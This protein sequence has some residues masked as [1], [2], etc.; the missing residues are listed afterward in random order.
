MPRTSHARLSP[1]ST[2]TLSV[3]ALLLTAGCV[4]RSTPTLS[5]SS[6]GAA[7]AQPSAETSPTTGGALWRAWDGNRLGLV[8]FAASVDGELFLRGGTGTGEDYVLEECAIDLETGEIRPLERLFSDESWWQL[9]FAYVATA[10]PPTLLRLRVDRNPLFQAAVDNDSQAPPVAAWASTAAVGRSLDAPLDFPSPVNADLGEA[11]LG[12][13]QP[14]AKPEQW[15]HA[16]EASDHDAVEDTRFTAPVSQVLCL[17]ERQQAVRVDLPQTTR[18]PLDLMPCRVQ[19]DQAH[20]ITEAYTPVPEELDWFGRY[21]GLSLVELGIELVDGRAAATTIF[22]PTVGPGD[23]AIMTSHTYD[24]GT[25]LAAFATL[26]SS[27]T[28]GEAWTEVRVYRA[29]HG[30]QE[31]VEGSPAGV[32][33]E[34]FDLAG[35]AGRRQL[36]APAVVWIGFWTGERVVTVTAGGQVRVLPGEA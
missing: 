26:E 2:V 25:G 5:A 12:L 31:L 33:V 22:S 11:D 30:E 16:N 6:G 32:P 20:L 23:L 17:R 28:N 27:G 10:L 34:P 3:A 36:P 13:V 15:I 1:T 18:L 29:K 7:A 9:H 19:A 4:Q 21:A 35:V 14:C 8:W 24:P